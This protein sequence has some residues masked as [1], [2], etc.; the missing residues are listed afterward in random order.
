MTAAVIT[1]HSVNNYGTQLQA[2]ATAEKLKEYFDD[3]VYIDYRRPDTYGMGL[4]QAT[5]KHNLLYVPLMLPT[6]LYWRTLFG[7]FRKEYLHFTDK[8]YLNESDFDHF[9]DI[10]DIYFSGSDQVWNTGWNGGVLPPFYLS[11]VPDTKPKFAYASS[12]GK[13]RYV[14]AKGRF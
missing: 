1:L 4:I 10:A 14:C 5:A 13:N 3:V 8:V 9:E 2:Y 11:F 12:F 6:W 7:G